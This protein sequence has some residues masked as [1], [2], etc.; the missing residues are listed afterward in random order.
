MSILDASV[1]L[2]Q[3]IALCILEGICI[4]LIPYLG[5][6][7]ILIMIDDYQVK[8]RNSL[9]HLKILEMFPTKLPFLK[10][11]CLYA[12]FFRLKVE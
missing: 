8:Y 6:I 5:D 9:L 3:F 2:L 4:F 10:Q 1:S 7:V 11:K 12:L